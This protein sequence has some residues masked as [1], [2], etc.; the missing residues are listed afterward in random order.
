MNDL[1]TIPL[2]MSTLEIA[3]LTGKRHDH[4]LRDADKMLVELG[5]STDPKFGA[6]YKDST[7]R[8][9]RLLNLPKRECLIL[10]SGYSTELRARIINRWIQLEAAQLVPEQLKFEIGRFLAMARQAIPQFERYNLRFAAGCAKILIEYLEATAP[11][12]EL[13]VYARNVLQI[14][15]EILAELEAKALW[16]QKNPPSPRNAH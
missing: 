12:P 5:I 7:G 8:T 3:G 6:S 10:V 16:L 1:S 14:G 2:T 4:V 15:L 13:L 9:L 11:E